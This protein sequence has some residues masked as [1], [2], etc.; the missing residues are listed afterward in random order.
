VRIKGITTVECD[1]CGI[2]KAKRQIRR[3]LREISEG[4]G[5]GKRIAID[6]HDFEEDEDN[7]NSLMLIT[8]RWSGYM[9]DFYL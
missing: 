1:A 8:D 2:S 6:F 7:Y 9:W 4:L 3:F 5:P